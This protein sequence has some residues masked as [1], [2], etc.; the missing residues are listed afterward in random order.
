M[1]T[2]PLQLISNS[3]KGSVNLYESVYEIT[4]GI[5]NSMTSHLKQEED[6]TDKTEITSKSH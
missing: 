2:L 5:V 6:M 1:K 3:L 4:N